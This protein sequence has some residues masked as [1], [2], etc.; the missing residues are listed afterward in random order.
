MHKLLLLE[1]LILAYDHLMV[2]QLHL[3][4]G[5]QHQRHQ[6][7]Q[8]NLMGLHK[9]LMDIPYQQALE[10]HQHSPKLLSLA[11]CLLLHCL[12][13]SQIQAPRLH[14]RHHQRV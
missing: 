12:L 10:R 2:E 3:D 7:H 14:L 11:K 9:H 5:R 6:R 8:H 13:H 1:Q 4:L